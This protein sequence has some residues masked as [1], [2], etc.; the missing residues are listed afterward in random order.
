MLIMTNENKGRH[1]RSIVRLHV[2]RRA[3][4]PTHALHHLRPKQSKMSHL[5][6]P[7]QIMDDHGANLVSK[8]SQLMV[9][10]L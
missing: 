4:F 10:Q 8:D 2:Q 5:R 3:K 7:S 6:C 9:P 1:G